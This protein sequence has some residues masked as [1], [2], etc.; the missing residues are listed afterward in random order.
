MG[1]FKCRHY[2]HLRRIRFSRKFVVRVSSP[3]FVVSSVLNRIRLFVAMDT[4][5]PNQ[6][7]APMHAEGAPAPAA[8]PAAVPTPGPTTVTFVEN[9]I[10]CQPSPGTTLRKLSKANGVKIQV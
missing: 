4:V 7:S 6:F 10:V 1:F 5:A 2:A 8:T 3:H 9:A